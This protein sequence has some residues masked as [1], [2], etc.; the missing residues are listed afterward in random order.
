VQHHVN[1]WSFGKTGKGPK[2]VVVVVVILNEDDN[3]III[4]FS[5]VGNL[6]TETQM[7]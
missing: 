4:T 2:A 5:L 1:G 3:V 7:E 6:G